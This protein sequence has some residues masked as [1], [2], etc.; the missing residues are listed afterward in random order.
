MKLSNL[1]GIPY[2]E[3]SHSLAGGG[4][5]CVGAC[6]AFY[7]AAGM[8]E[9]RTQ[10]AQ[11]VLLGGPS[12]DWAAVYPADGYLIGD[13]VFTVASTGEAHVAVIVSVAPEI[14]LSS[15]RL[16]GTY[17]RPLA[18]MRGLVGVYRPTLGTE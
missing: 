14:T 18:E 15:A 9:A 11:A 13:L 1:I 16:Q 3:G 4:L 8:N 10:L 7:D 6:L 17:L 12:R 2:V 5:D